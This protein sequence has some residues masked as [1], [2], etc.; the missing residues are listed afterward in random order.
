M[1]GYHENPLYHSDV[2]LYGEVLNYPTYRYYTC[3]HI[4]RNCRMAVSMVLKDLNRQ[5]L[6]TFLLGKVIFF[7]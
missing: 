5:K 7:S 4:L 1:C 6:K 2:L 3:I